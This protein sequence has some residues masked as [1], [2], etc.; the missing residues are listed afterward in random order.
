[1]WRK[2]VSRCSKRGRSRIAIHFETQIWGCGTWVELGQGANLSGVRGVFEACETAYL[3]RNL[4]NVSGEHKY[5]ALKASESH[6]DPDSL[7]WH[8]AESDSDDVSR[9]RASTAV[10]R[11]QVS[12]QL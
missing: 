7:L 1:M 11:M 5:M 3:E 2:E 8:V 9:P 12:E 4:C 6:H 10:Q